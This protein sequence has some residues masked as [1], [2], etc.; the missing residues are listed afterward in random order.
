V[1]GGFAAQL[2]C[3]AHLKLVHRGRG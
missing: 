1:E 2:E 3:G